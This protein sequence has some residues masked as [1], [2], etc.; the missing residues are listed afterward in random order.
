M[1]CGGM[2]LALLSVPQMARHR[3][4][5]MAKPVL[6]PNSLTPFVDPLPIL[7]VATYLLAS[8]RACIALLLPRPA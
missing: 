7:K 3:Q 5:T 6:D 8:S 4:V 2:S 1:K